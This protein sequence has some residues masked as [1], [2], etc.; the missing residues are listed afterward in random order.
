MPHVNQH[1]FGPGSLEMLRLDVWTAGVEERHDGQRAVKI[2]ARLLGQY[3]IFGELG[4]ERIHIDVSDAVW[5]TEPGMYTD[6]FIKARAGMQDAGERVAS[7]ML[8]WAL[9]EWDQT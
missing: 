8:V 4:Q 5:S 9:E 6:D 1:L 3:D 7:Q 2:K